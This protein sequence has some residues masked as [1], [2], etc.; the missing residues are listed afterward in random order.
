MRCMNRRF[1]YLL[2]GAKMATDSSETK[3]PGQYGRGGVS[4]FTLLTSV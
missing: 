4:L 1:T 2:A 3:F